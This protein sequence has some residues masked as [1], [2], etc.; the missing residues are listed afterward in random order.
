MK[1]LRTTALSSFR[2]LALACIAGVIL[3]LFSTQYNVAS[4]DNLYRQLSL[5]MTGTDVYDLQTFLAKDSSIYPQGLVTGYFGPL[6]AQAVRNF[7]SRYGISPV[8]RVGPITLAAINSQMSGTVSTSS[9]L[10][11]PS[12]SKP[13]VA[14]SRNS[15]I[16]SWTTNE[17]ARA[18]VYYSSTP[19]TTYERDNAVDV[20]GLT[21]SADSA[22]HTS[23]SVTLTGL[24]PNTVYYYLVY[25]TDEQGNVSV[26]WPTMFTTAI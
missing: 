23:H 7:Q 11:A 2:L 5:G 18:V 19:L 20:S 24:N 25:V 1:Q 3:A 6:T 26:T 4:A 8:G 13:A 22:F 17:N 10:A 9:P 16:L 15:A 12:I 21:A 14:A